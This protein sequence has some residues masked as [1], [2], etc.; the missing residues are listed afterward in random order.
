MMLAPRMMDGR[1]WSRWI[2]LD[3]A[4]GTKDKTYPETFFDADAQEIAYGPHSGDTC[5]EIPP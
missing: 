4:D 3:T 5:R 2:Y 1:V